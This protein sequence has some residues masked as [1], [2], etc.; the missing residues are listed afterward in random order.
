MAGLELMA[1]EFLMKRRT[2]VLSDAT[3]SATADLIDMLNL[4]EKGASWSDKDKPA[5]SQNINGFSWL[6]GPDDCIE[7]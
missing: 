3:G 5:V 6:K 1:E 7:N 2:I 4:T